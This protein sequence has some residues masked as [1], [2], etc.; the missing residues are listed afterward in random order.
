MDCDTTQPET[1]LQDTFYQ[2]C[3][4]IRHSNSL[5]EWLEAFHQLTPDDLEALKWGRDV[6]CSSRGLTLE[7][8]IGGCRWCWLEYLEGFA[9]IET[10]SVCAA[11]YAQQVEGGVRLA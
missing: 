9:D 3:N 7:G 2:F 4:T 6:Y 10:L 5:S 11:T 8:I 1:D